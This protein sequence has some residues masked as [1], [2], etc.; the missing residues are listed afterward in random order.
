MLHD[1]VTSG[2][3]YGGSHL[4]TLTENWGG[5]FLSA[6]DLT[7]LVQVRPGDS[8]GFSKACVQTL[9]ATSYYTVVNVHHEP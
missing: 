1:E 4:K 3:P 9:Q 6:G 7:C 2:C 5:C 8:V